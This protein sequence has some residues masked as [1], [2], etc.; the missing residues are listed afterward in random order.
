MDISDV[1]NFIET[2]QNLVTEDTVTNYS[3]LTPA[4]ISV[5]EGGKYFKVISGGSC[6]GFISKYD[7]H[8]K[9]IPIKVG[10]LMKGANW[11]SPAKHS[12]GNILDGTASY[13]VHGPTYLK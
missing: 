2:V 13:G 9:G 11:S 10:D 4:V 6:W 5:T 12:R 1:N 8:F 3:S 7:G